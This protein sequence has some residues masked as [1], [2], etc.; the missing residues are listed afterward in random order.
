M[1]ILLT[2]IAT[3]WCAC[4]IITAALLVVYDKHRLNEIRFFYYVTCILTF[5][6]MSYLYF[7]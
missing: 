3:V 4:I 6:L 5:I 2:I 7:K 1:K